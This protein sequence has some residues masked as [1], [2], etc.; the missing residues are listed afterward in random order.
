MAWSTSTAR[1]TCNARRPD[2]G[3]GAGADDVIVQVRAAW[4]PFYPPPPRRYLRPTA[5]RRPE[6]H[7]SKAAPHLTIDVPPGTVVFDADTGAQLGDLTTPDETLVVCRGGRGGRGNQHFATSRNQAPRTAEKGEPGA[8]KRLKLE[9][10]LIADIGVIGV[11][12]AGK[13][14]LLA[15]LTNAG[16]RSPYPYDP[17]AEPGAWRVDEYAVWCWPTFPA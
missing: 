5:R 2:G 1:S 17:R 11:P 4:A 9:L 13:S 7:V 15:A 10:K 14:T 6:Q 8:E 16:R 12:N 3:D